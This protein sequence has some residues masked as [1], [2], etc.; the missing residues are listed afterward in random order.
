MSEDTRGVLDERD[1]PLQEQI[2]ETL[3]RQN[4]MVTRESRVVFVIPPWKSDHWTYGAMYDYKPEL[5]C[6]LK[7]NADIVLPTV[8]A[9]GL[10]VPDTAI[11]VFWPENTDEPS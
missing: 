7:S 10:Y 3:G 6:A 4:V 9:V 2:R 1:A 5:Y 11:Y 8:G